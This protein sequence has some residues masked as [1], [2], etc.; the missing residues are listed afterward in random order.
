MSKP[1]IVE[2]RLR[3]TL[4]LDEGAELEDVVKNLIV[5]DGSYSADV[6]DDE[7]LEWEKIKNDR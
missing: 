5:Y 3:V 7:I 1:D 6:L 2:V 4:N